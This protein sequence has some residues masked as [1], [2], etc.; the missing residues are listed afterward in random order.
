MCY[1]DSTPAFV[2]YCHTETWS[3]LWVEEFLK[4]LGYE[5]DDKMHVYWQL[6]GKNICDGLVCMQSDADIV[7][8]IK[9]VSSHKTLCLMVDHTNF[10][11]R[12]RDDVIINGGP[13]LPPVISPKKIPKKAVKMSVVLHD[14]ELQS[15]RKSV[16]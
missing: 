1:I 5:K 11:K 2:D 15:D 14:S 13:P 4:Q 10:I 3:L 8:M 7:E 12:L 9:S 16:V 6:P